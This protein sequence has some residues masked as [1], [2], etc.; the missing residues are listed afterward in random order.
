MQPAGGVDDHDVA[1]AGLGRGD[2]IERH[3]R[4]IRA[5]LRADEID[6]RALRPD[7]QLLDRR[8][9]E[10]VGRADQHRLGPSMRYQFAS[11]PTVVVLPVPLTPT[12]RMTCGR[13]VTLRRR[14]HVR[15]DARASRGRPGRRAIRARSARTASRI[16]RSP[17]ARRRRRSARLPALRCCR[18]RATR[19][20]PAGSGRRGRSGS[21][22]ALAQPLA[23]LLRCLRE[24]VANAVKERCHVSC[25]AP[26]CFVALRPQHQMADGVA[27]G[28]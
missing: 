12:T 27:R 26:S 10:R 8:G 6:A 23:N 14:L 3:R 25:R 19:G 1:A 7:R 18:S 15:Q 9:A 11:L 28:F 24:A 22:T 13:V 5:R 20:R 4:R 17:A 21:A 2:R 16:A